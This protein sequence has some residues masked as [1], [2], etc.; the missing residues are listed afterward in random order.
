MIGFVNGEKLLT[1]SDLPPQWNLL[2]GSS[3]W[4]GAW[5]QATSGDGSLTNLKDQYGNLFVRH[6]TR[7]WQGTNQSCYLTESRF[8]TFSLIFKN[9]TKTISHC[10]FFANQFADATAEIQPVATYIDGSK[11][12][13]DDGGNI[14][15]PKDD[16]EH[17]ISFTFTVTKSGISNLRMEVPEGGSYLISSFK[18]EYGTKATRWMPAITDLML[19]NENGG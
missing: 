8:Y 5:Y 16:L 6:S 19:K 18:L 7:A 11:V 4:S 14:A 1:E 2:K 17:I 3:N 13:A 10:Q 15:L 9:E 12:V